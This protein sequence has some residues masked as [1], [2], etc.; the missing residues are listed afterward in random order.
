MSMIENRSG[1]FWRFD[2]AGI[3][4]SSVGGG[5]SRLGRQYR[6]TLDGARTLSWRRAILVSV[7]CSA[8]LSANRIEAQ[9][10]ERIVQ[11]DDEPRCRRC[12]IRFTVQPVRDDS[13][14]PLLASDLS[15]LVALNGDRFLATQFAAQMGLP[16]IIRSDGRLS[17]GLFIRGQGPGEFQV[18]A[19]AASW[20][21]DS[22]LV[23]DPALG[24]VSVLSPSGVPVRTEVAS[25]LSRS[26][27]LITLPSGHL[28]ASLVATTRN[29]VGAPL[30]V[31]A[32]DWWAGRVIGRR[33]GKFL[34]ADRGHLRRRLATAIDSGFWAAHVTAYEIEKWSESGELTLRVVRRA[35]WFEPHKLEVPTA[36]EPPPRPLLIGVWQESQ[37]RLW[38]VS[39]VA[40]TKWRS[41]FGAVQR[42]S[43]GSFARLERTD[44]YV[45]TIV[46][47]LD[48]DGRCVLA[49]ATL[50]GAASAVSGTGVIAVSTTAPDGTVTA[51]LHRAELVQPSEQERLPC[52]DRSSTNG[53]KAGG[54]GCS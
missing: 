2:P 8:L 40:D 12:K 52:L 30:Q 35:P 5:R 29:E 48:V 23:L 3:V 16:L 54:C 45:D 10:A 27:G 21:G 33:G 31:F 51:S 7:V 11:I 17:S 37:K 13:D 20:R 9:N 26:T 39:L 6:R 1:R 50:E 18:A 44:L 49:R 47:V 41:A 14:A 43:R 53:S 22:V 36:T 24:R 15:S 46:E 19:L 32:S 42:S 25:P 4:V 38:V 34:P 28:V